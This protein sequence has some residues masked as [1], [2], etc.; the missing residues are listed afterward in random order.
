MD[1]WNPARSDWEKALDG[2]GAANR[3]AIQMNAAQMNRVRDA[4]CKCIIASYAI[5]M[6]PSAVNQRSLLWLFGCRPQRPY[7]TIIVEVYTI[8]VAYTPTFDQFGI[9]TNTAGFKGA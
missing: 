9:K 4:T 2:D 5:R 3:K 7:L 1:R 8:G 6:G